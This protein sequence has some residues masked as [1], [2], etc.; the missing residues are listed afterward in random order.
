MFFIC[1]R[2][3]AFNIVKIDNLGEEILCT[4]R[5]TSRDLIVPSAWIAIP[6]EALVF[7]ISEFDLEH[8]DLKEKKS[9]SSFYCLESQFH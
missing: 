3:V 4:L 5:A 1:L 6:V 7:E 2:V 9:A 8:T